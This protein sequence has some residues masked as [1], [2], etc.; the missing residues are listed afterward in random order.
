MIPIRD[1]TR[2]KNYPL[3]NNTLIVI[4]VI[5]FIMGMGNSDQFILMYGFT[6]ARYTMP[7]IASYFTFSQQL[8]ALVSFMFLHGGFWHLVGN[9]WFLYIF[10]DN[11]ED[12]LGHIRYLV[13]YLLCGWASAIVHL[14]FNWSSQVPTVGASGAIAGVMGAYLI[15]YPTSRILTLIPIIIIPYFIEIPAV[16]FLGFWILFQFLSAT[17]ID[18]NTGGI[19]W[20]AH[21]GGFLFGIIA[22]RI[23]LSIPQS[24]VAE[25]FHMFTKRDR[26]PR[27]HR[28]K[29]VHGDDTYNLY[30]TI[31]ITPR[32]AEK[33]TRKMIN[34]AQEYQKKLFR[35]NVAPGTRDGT[36]LRL[37]GIGKKKGDRERGDVF[38]KVRIEP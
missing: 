21:I 10:G 38:L 4:N 29:P 19:A 16:F 35:L 31:L 24:K 7:E 20:W 2:S 28:I 11:I 32:E 1:T 37:A 23:F 17:L 36:V 25:Q 18:P 8:F 14:F 6:P 33:G 22:V 34:I 5:V 30:G 15:L 27:L 26:T 12:R 13:F 3:I 9:M